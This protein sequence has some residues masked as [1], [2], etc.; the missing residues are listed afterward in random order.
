MDILIM[1]IYLEQF[2]NQI[3]QGDCHETMLWLPD[4]SVDLVVTDPPY[5]FISKN[6]EGGGFMNKENKLHLQKINKS[7]GMTYDPKGYLNECKR[8]LKKF[9]GY[10]WTNKSLLTQY[11]KFAEDNKYKWDILIWAKPNPVPINNG[12]YLIDKEF[13]VYIKE[14]NATFN[15][16]LGYPKYF[17]VKTH[18]IGTKITEHPTEKPLGFHED[19]I[20]ISSNPGDVV[21]DGY[22]GSGTTLVAAKNLLRQYIG[23][24][25]N[26]DFIAMAEKRL[27]Q[28]TLGF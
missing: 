10:F 4:H 6:P 19:M 14:P 1:L 3:I 11:I 21:F 13:V 9:N 22:A 28:E 23:I 8:I 18:P 24:E 27:K 15:S 25:I 7:F 16:K 2:I 17:T 12:H 20:G 5:E 26:P